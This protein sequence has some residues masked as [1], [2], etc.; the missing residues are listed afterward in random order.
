M[1]SWVLRASYLGMRDLWKGYQVTCYYTS[2]P[3]NPPTSL[4]A[5]SLDE[6]YR[7]LIMVSKLTV[8]KAVLK[9]IFKMS[10]REDFSGSGRQKIKTGRRHKKIWKKEHVYIVNRKIYKCMNILCNNLVHPGFY[11]SRFYINILHLERK[12]RYKASLPKNT[13]LGNVLKF[14]EKLVWE[15]Q[16]FH[17]AQ[18]LH[19]KSCTLTM[20]NKYKK[21]IEEPTIRLSINLMR[22]SVNG[23]WFLW[24]M[25]V[26][27]TFSPL[28][29]HYVC[30]LIRYILRLFL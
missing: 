5:L 19:L 29:A 1:T 27:S 17:V 12:P 30:R 22:N 9:Y 25:K 21:L 28:I 10:S 16:H 15:S 11:E 26:R 20:Y 2:L 7:T 8:L 14:K 18:C 24:S 4:V 23:N 6:N 13:L 3:L